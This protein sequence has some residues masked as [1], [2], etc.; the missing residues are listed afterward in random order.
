MIL[1]AL[2]V[3]HSLKAHLMFAALSYLLKF[4]SFENCR[5][6]KVSSFKFDGSNL[7]IVGTPIRL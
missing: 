5:V 1:L 7:Y 6:L 2:S 3:Y 4:I